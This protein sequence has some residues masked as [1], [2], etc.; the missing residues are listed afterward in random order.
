MNN[1]SSKGRTI[2]IV[3]WI[4]AFLLM[5]GAGV[6]QRLTGPTHPMRGSIEVAGE[7]V[8]YRLI[9]AAWTDEQA[10]IEVPSVPGVDGGVV[11]W[12]RYPTEEAWSEEPLVLDGENWIARLPIQPAAG[13]LEYS[14][15]LSVEGSQ[16]RL[17]EV[18]RGN[19]ILRYR[20]PVPLGVL[21]PHIFFM[22]FAVLIAWRAGLGALI[23][24]YGMRRL[25]WWALGLFTVGG[26]ILG[27]VVQKYAFGAY[28]TGIP[29]G[30]D[31]T[32]NK[33]LVMWLAWLVAALVLERVARRN[34]QDAAVSDRSG[35]GVR[36]LILAASVVTV[37]VYLIPHSVQGSELDYEAIDQGVPAEE[38]IGIG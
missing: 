31:L 35:G 14:I 24:P 30:W 34:P 6:Y 26:M 17:P 27:P 38:A 2:R 9:R 16:V 28:W 4:L 15:D 11:S 3:L 32:D 22:F 20:D 5:L 19:A 18:E 29:F 33:T 36:G 10:R 23:H 7:P 8:T 37:F 25:A 1:S 12:R 13:K 21:I